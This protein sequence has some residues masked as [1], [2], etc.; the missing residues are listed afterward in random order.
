MKT[1]EEIKAIYKVLEEEIKIFSYEKSP[2]M[3]LRYKAK[4]DML[5]WILDTSTIKCTQCFDLGLIEHWDEEQKRNVWRDCDCSLRKNKI[6][7]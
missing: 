3:Y 1:E 4:L 2:I 5:E 7:Q 6:T